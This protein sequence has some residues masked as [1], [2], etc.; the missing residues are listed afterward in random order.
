LLLIGLIFP[1]DAL[2]V[3]IKN[4][5]W[6]LKMK[7]HGLYIHI[8]FC[9]VKCDYCSFYVVAGGHDLTTTLV[10]AMISQLSVLAETHRFKT[11]Y[12]GGGSPS[13]LSLKDLFRLV[14][15]AMVMATED[16]ECSIEVNP[17]QVTLEMITGLHARGVRRLSLGAQS[18][19]LDELIFLSR[20]YQPA[21]I[22]EAF[23]IGRNGGFDNVSL[24]LIFAVCGTTA[25]KWMDSLAQAIALDPEH[26]STYALTFEPGTKLYKNLVDG[27]VAQVP[28][29]LDREMYIAGIKTLALHGYERYEVSNFA[30]AGFWCAHN[31]RYWQNDSY[32]GIGPC[33]ASFYD[34]IR[35]TNI[36]GI[37]RYIA[38]VKS[39]DSVI[40][41]SY[42]TVGKQLACETAV[43]MLRQGRGVDF[44]AFKRRT[45]MSFPS[46]F[47][48]SLKHNIDVGLLARTEQGVKLTTE[49]VCIADSVL[50][51][52]AIED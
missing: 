16:I 12:F 11:I 46:L 44:A 35:S 34:G 18:F 32:I 10:D 33:A 26:I 28:Q 13:Y 43:L 7:H 20:T 30:K 3:L 52:F 17:D 19:H 23:D 14:E 2:Y 48:K 29:R 5:A 25:E 41:E 40:D 1:G 36:K 21:K 38:S 22:Y 49:G 15:A 47:G 50:S 8:P 9:Q 31:L 39:G 45:K 37:K 6:K 27:K 51:D 24:D 42:Q 4:H